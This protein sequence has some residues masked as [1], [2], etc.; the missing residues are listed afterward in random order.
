MNTL[1]YDDW[2]NSLPDEQRVLVQQIML[3]LGRLL[4]SRYSAL[5]DDIQRMERRLATQSGKI[6]E[7]HT[8]LD[9]YETH[10]WTM[11]KEAIE[12]FAITQLPAERREE[13]IAMLYQLAADVEELRAKVA[14]ESDASTT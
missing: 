8:R 13:L 3:R 6:A 9:Q 7:L 11:A 1:Q 5:I 4:D 2:I 12:Q 10:Q 14:G